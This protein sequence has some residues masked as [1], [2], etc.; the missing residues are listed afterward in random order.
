[1]TDQQTDTA[2]GVEPITDHESLRGR[3]PF[4]EETDVAPAETVESLAAAEDMA[5]VGITNDA[6]EVLFRR[7][8]PTCSWKLPV[9]LVGESEEYAAA[10]R[11]HVTETIGGI[12]LRA[13]EGVW[14]VDARTEDG[15]AAASRTFV[16]FSGTL[17]NETIQV[18]ADGVEEAGW[19]DDR[20]EEAS[21]LPGT[22]LFL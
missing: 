9:A 8:T 7:L 1:M 4:H 2:P 14:H 20:P 3:V 18:P 11:E 10:I 21:S 17:E 5:I 22:D 15:A 19:F 13:V 12:D 6:G 16:V